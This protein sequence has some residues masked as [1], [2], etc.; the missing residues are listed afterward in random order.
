MKRFWEKVNKTD[1]C[2]EW[3]AAI[4]GNSGYGA[5]KI[6]GKVVDAHRFSY[7]LHYGEIPNGML[8]CHKCDNRLCV[9]P[10][11]LFL[12]TYKENKQDA[13]KKGR[14]LP[15]WN[16]EKLKKHPSESAYRRGCRCFECVGIARKSRT[17]RMRKYRNRIN[18]INATH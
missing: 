2:W 16:N 13:V 12:G 18:Q 10:D 7:K 5:F 1:S 11:H 3:K 14:M 15:A 9:N 17:E 6:N 8:V 4:R